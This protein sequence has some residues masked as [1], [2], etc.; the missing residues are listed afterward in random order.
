MAGM[1]AISG[2]LART[3]YARNGNGRRSPRGAIYNAPTG[4]SASM[5]TDCVAGLRR[6]DFARWVL[7]D[8][9]YLRHNL[10]NARN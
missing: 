2:M 8:E 4:D 5:A 1:V 6:P 9:T 3:G 7:V 10:S